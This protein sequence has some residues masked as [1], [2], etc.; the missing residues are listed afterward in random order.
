M[1]LNRLSSAQRNWRE[2]TPKE[3]W[4]EKKEVIASALGTIVL[5]GICGGSFYGTCWA[6]HLNSTL[7]FTVLGFAPM[8]LIAAIGGITLAFFASTIDHEKDRFSGYT[9]RLFDEEVCKDRIDL[10][11]EESIWEIYKQLY[12]REMG[13]GPY[14][15]A[16]LLSVDQGE[17]LSSF[18]R[19]YKKLTSSEL[20][21]KG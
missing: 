2:L 8:S 18:L 19:D 11:N 12:G 5:F 1:A 9:P 10:L 17:G 21:H 6:L 20:E 13:V 16:G 15:R 7:G 3:A 4:A 14:V